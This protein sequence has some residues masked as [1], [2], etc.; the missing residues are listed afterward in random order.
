MIRFLVTILL[1][2]LAYLG[3]TAIGK[4]DTTM[5]ILVFDYKIDIS[6]FLLAV[7]I[8]IAMT[9]SSLGVRVIGMILKMPYVIA[10]KLSGYKKRSR[11][12]TIMESYGQ[13]IVG[14]LDTA[15]RMIS[16]IDTKDLD[17]EYKEHI[18]LLATICNQDFDKNMPMLQN[19]L[20]N[21]EYHDFAAKT[22]AKK[23]FDQGYYAQSLQ[24][25]EQVRLA[26]T[27][28]PEVMYLLVK[29]YA[30]LD[31]WDKFHISIER[32]VGIYAKQAQDLA[33]E[34]GLY[35]LKAAKF[36]LAEGAETKAMEYL[37]KSLEYNPINQ[38]AIEMFCKLNLTLGRG[39]VN[40]DVLER[41]FSIVPSFAIFELYCQSSTINAREIY[42]KLG[43][44]V[45]IISYRDIFFAI[46][47]YLDLQE[48]IKALRR[49]ST[50]MLLT[51]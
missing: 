28:D 6:M 22:L 23:L 18:N 39:G 41:A 10:E 51:L 16:R 47:A 4:Y 48:E 11:V 8:I 17:V 31:M 9:L 26:T 32:Y 25:A 40:L 29:L 24:Y 14:N 50:E 35:Y 7:I 49:D 38:E 20:S 15:Q 21:K 37:Q 13:V 34:I 44:L 19:L 46:A 2:A 5:S 45:D 27:N 36:T 33:T 43:S 1:L 12:R 42:H 30:H 3:I